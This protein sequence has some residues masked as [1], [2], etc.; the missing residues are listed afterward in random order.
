MIHRCRIRLMLPGFM[1]AF[2]LAAA[3]LSGC[4]QESSTTTAQAGKSQQPDV[5]AV[6]KTVPEMNLPADGAALFAKLCSSC[7]GTAGNGRGSRSGPS[8]QRPEFSYG[9][10]PAAI[11]Q[12]I[13]DGRPGGMPA[14]GHVFTPRQFEALTMYI[15]SL[16]K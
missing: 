10:T 5:K 12:S 6:G 11:T 15:L 3:L 9:R 2:I 16:K 13:R 8:L 1:M 14:F 7:H 4:I